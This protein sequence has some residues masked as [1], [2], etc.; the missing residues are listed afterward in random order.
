M[1]LL[2]DWLRISFDIILNAFIEI[3]YKVEITY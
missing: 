1:T 2:K 3:I